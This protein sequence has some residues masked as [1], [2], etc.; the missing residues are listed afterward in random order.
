MHSLM[1][2][3]IHCVSCLLEKL[4]EVQYDITLVQWPLFQMLTKI[5]LALKGLSVPLYMTFIPNGFFRKHYSNQ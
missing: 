1:E 3:S 5:A 2:R 4:I